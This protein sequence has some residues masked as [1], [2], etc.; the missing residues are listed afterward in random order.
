MT[1]F[2]SRLFAVVWALIGLVMTSLVI[3]AIVTALTTVNGA[4]QFKIYG[5]QVGALNGSFEEKLGLLRNGKVNQSKSFKTFKSRD[6]QEQPISH[7]QN[8]IESPSLPALACTVDIFCIKIIT[9]VIYPSAYHFA[10]VADVFL[11]LV[12]ST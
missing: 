11:H 9:H 6:I 7:K 8:M 12:H 3:G 4:A 10:S 1:K 2:H 5:S